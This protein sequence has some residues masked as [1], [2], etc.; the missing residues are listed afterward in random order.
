MRM[1][2]DL[3]A[4][5]RELWRW[6]ESLG[7]P[8]RLSLR[9]LT[10]LTRWVAAGPQAASC[11]R[12]QACQWP[13]LSHSW[14]IASISWR[15]L[16]VPSSLR[17]LVMRAAS[18]W[19]WFVRP[20]AEHPPA[21]AIMILCRQPWRQPPCRRTR[22]LGCQAWPPRRG[23]AAAARGLDSWLSGTLEAVT[24]SWPVSSGWIVPNLN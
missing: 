12:F 5:G 16:P 10:L 4:R 18:Q 20:R 11:R 3:P 21:R 19:L 24:A 6:P 17:V 13:I 8:T 14:G 9:L 1:S 15:A 23:P 7:T 22:G 2:V